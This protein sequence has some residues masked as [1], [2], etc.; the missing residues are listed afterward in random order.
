MGLSALQK[1]ST[2]TEEKKQQR[3]NKH[4]N[5]TA[6]FKLEL[7]LVSPLNS[8]LRMVF[9]NVV[10]VFCSS[11]GGRSV[12]QRKEIEASGRDCFG[13]STG[14]SSPCARHQ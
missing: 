11:L 2:K 4:T 12:I 10:N 6:D 3:E 9:L 5:T 14:V 13:S 7:F 1:P 8:S